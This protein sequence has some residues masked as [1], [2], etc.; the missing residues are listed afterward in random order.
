MATIKDVAKEAGVSTAT[1]SRVLNNSSS[2]SEKTLDK[3]NK[4]MKALNYHPNAVARSLVKGKHYSIGVMLPSLLVPFW[5]QIA[6]ELEKTTAQYG[7]SVIITEA[8]SSAEAYIKKFESLRARMP[9]GIITSYI[10]DTEHYIRQSDTPTVI[11]GNV[12]YPPSVSSNDGQGG[13]L[14]ARHLIAKGC[15]RIIH[16]SGEMGSR[17]SANARTH[18]FIKECEEKH[19]EYKVYQ[20]TDRQT[21]EMDY[22]PVI[23]NIFYEN[24]EFDGIFASNDILAAHCISMALS[25]GYQIPGDIRIIGY[26]DINISKLIYPPLTT[27][28]QNY[29]VLAK[30]SV[31]TLLKLM[32]QE[33]VPEKQIIPVELVERKTT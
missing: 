22:A 10:K 32:A 5:A 17:S 7:Y 11:I 15:K 27:I 14:A 28:R 19:I 30:T 9:D 13:L 21:R 23:S 1:V 31:D 26:D 2:L 20:S 3:V 29:P 8:P 33:E 25:L 6:N 24:P 4:A 16:I 18:A 12:D